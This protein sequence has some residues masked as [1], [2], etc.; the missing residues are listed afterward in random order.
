MQEVYN[1]LD[2]IESGKGASLQFRHWGREE[3]RFL[4]E[5]GARQKEMAKSRLNG[6]EVAVG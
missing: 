1:F 4:D 2:T 6:N 5:A 3:G